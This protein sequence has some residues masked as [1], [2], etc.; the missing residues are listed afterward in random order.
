M[1]KQQKLNWR[2]QAAEETEIPVEEEATDE[3]FEAEKVDTGLNGNPFVDFRAGR[4]NNVPPGG[5]GGDPPVNGG[6]GEDLPRGFTAFQIREIL[7]LPASDHPG[8]QLV[9]AQLTGTNFINWS[10]SIKRAL[11]ARSKLDFITGNLPM[12]PVTSRYYTQ[13][14]KVDFMVSTWIVNSISK[15]FVNAFTHIDNTAR[16]W[17]AITLRFGRRNGPK[18]YRLQKEI[19]KFNQGTQS[20]LEYFN[21]LVALWDELDAVLPPLDCMCNARG[22]AIVRE[23]QQRLMK[24]LEGLNESY[25]SVIDQIMMLDPLPDLDRAYSLIVQ[26]EDRKILTQTAENGHIMSMNVTHQGYNSTAGAKGPTFKKRLTKEQRKRLK[27]SH[28]LANGHEADECFKLHGIPEWYKKLKENKMGGRVNM[29][30]GEDEGSVSSHGGSE[31]KEH[32]DGG[33]DISKVIQAEIAKYVGS[34]FQQHNATTKTDVNLVHN[35][36]VKDSPFEGHYAFSVLEEMERSIW[37]IDS[38]ASVHICCTLDQMYTTYKLDKRI[39]VRLP[40]G[41]TIEVSTGG[42]VRLN[43]DIALLNVLYIPGF[44]HNLLSVARLI[45]DSGIKCVFY[46]SHCVFQQDNTDRILGVGKMEKNLYIMQGPAEAF[47]VSFTNPKNLSLA[48]WHVCMGHPSLQTMKH[49]KVFTDKQL[50][51]IDDV[52]KDCEVCVQAKQSRDVF[53]ILNRR[54]EGLFEMVHVDLWGPYSVENVCSVKYML[55]I[56]ED[57]SRMIWIYLLNSK[58]QVAGILRDYVVMIKTQFHKDIQQVRSD[59]GS[60]FV[61]KRV[62]DLF[63]QNGILHQRSCPYTP[64]QNG[65]V[66]RRHRSLMNTARALMFCSGLPMKFWP[67]S[68]LMATWLSNRT[69]SR[70]I[71]WN[72]PYEILFMDQPDFSMLKPFGCL[73]HAVDLSPTRGKFDSRSIRS[74]FLGY[75][76]AYKGFLLYDLD[77]NRTFVS[78]DVK[79]FPNKFPFKDSISSSSTAPIE[80][81]SPHVDI[82]I[83]DHDLFIPSVGELDDTASSIDDSTDEQVDD[84]LPSSTASPP[85]PPNPPNPPPPIA[86]EGRIRKP[87]TWLQDYVCNFTYSSLGVSS[88]SLTPPTF[89]FLVSSALSPSYVEFLFNLSVVKEP[90]TFTEASKSLEW[91]DAM[92]RELLALSENKTWILTDL[93]AGKKPIGC[94]WVFKIKHNPDGTVERYKARLVAKGYNQKYGKD[95]TEVFSPVA[96]MVTVR[97]M[98]AMSAAQDWHIH[99]LDVNNAFLHGFLR[100]DIYMSVPPGFKGAKPGQVCKLVKSLYGLKQ[101]SREWNLE[102]TK[103]LKIFGFSQSQSDHCLFIKGSGSS[104]LCLLV[105]VDDVLVC[106]PSLELIADLKKFLHSTFTIKDLGE[107]KY[108]LGMEIIRGRDGIA[109]NQRKYVL[110]IVGS[111][112]LMGCRPTQTP[113]SPGCVLSRKDGAYMEDAEPYRRVVGQLLYLNLTRPDITF[114]AQQ[115]SQFV[116]RPTVTHW[117]AAMHVLKYLKGCPSLGVFYS[118]HCDFKLQAFS[119][120]DWGTCVDSRRSLT[121]YCIFFGSGLV[122]WKCKKQPTVASSTAEAEYRAMSLTTRELVWLSYLFHDF[123]VPLDLPIPL[124]CDNLAAIHITKNSVFHEKTKHIEMDC[125]IVREKF[126]SGLLTPVATTSLAQLADFFT[127][128]LASPRFRDLL[129]KMGLVDVHQFHLAGGCGNGGSDVKNSGDGVAG[130]AGKKKKGGRDGG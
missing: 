114:A 48:E 74:V 45:H 37:V 128:S 121:G 130:E 111:A 16:L 29:V 35:T 50:L 22:V 62:Y 70:V 41:S 13:W 79:F 105:Y 21:N 71:D 102:F 59:N 67:H 110:D 57:F 120:A 10:K 83:D 101:A 15:E 122:S 75:D 43:E 49:M 11:A 7:S 96:K 68:L 63:A 14:L 97:F 47:H 23:E 44:T 80:A 90:T 31:Q 119:D 5:E 95:Y 94:K 98:L 38:G 89:P 78:R 127:K 25:E 107:A 123:L 113:F 55:T 104:M 42:T 85:N 30:E 69:P 86:R 60:E 103:Q 66:E 34:Y 92:D 129:S 88:S 12:P 116:A 6:G 61:N 118:A 28:C 124:H 81:S 115:L 39:E 117:N 4:Q 126:V 54:T 72:T 125:H 51:D 24:F 77:H 9:S 99:Q 87:P 73:A 19:F 82:P 52:I 112:G 76:L 100:D 58:D 1:V 64:Q 109:L 33:M 91:V 65:V 26:V 8:I 93:P 3:E 27:C 46:T 18:V 108:F 53:P 40:D 84:S 2:A 36:Q 20:V 32:K 56:V 106:G 17:K